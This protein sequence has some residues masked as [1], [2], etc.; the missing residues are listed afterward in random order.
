MVRGCRVVVPRK[1]RAQAL[2]MLH[3]A[4]PGMSRMKSLAR[5]YLGH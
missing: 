2:Q 3:D 5:S 4:H 1:G